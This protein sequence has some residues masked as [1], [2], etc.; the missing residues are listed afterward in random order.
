[1][2][3]NPFD[4]G[5]QM[6]RIVFAIAAGWT[7]LLAL[8]GLFTPRNGLRVYW[9][10]ETDRAL[11]R[12]LQWLSSVLMLALACSY[13]L[14]AWEPASWLALVAVGVAAKA[15]FSLA[16][17]TFHI[18]GRNSDTVAVVALLEGVLAVFFVIYLVGGARSF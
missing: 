16:T 1:M 11:P 4:W 5:Y 12:L 8:P 15:V 7:V 14:I 10:I 6:W 9:G 13:A 17:L 2:T 18:R 3:F